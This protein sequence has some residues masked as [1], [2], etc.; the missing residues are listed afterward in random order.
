MTQ[1]TNTK[2]SG[3]EE[4]IENELVNLHGYRA[5]GASAYDKGLCMDTE[6]VLEFVKNTQAENWEKL[7][8][9]YGDEVGQKFLERLDGEIADRG[10]LAVLREG[11]KDRGVKFRL[12]YW[13]PQTGMNPETLTDYEANI[14][15]VT[16]QVK[17]SQQNENSIDMVLFVNGLPIFTVELKNQLTGQTVLHAM[18]QYKSDRDQREKLLSFKR[19]LTHFAVDTEQVYMTTRLS[20]LST[21]FLPFNRGDNNGSGNPVVA[22][23]YKTHYLWE[24]VWGRDSLM[25]LL[26]NFIALQTE[27]KVDKNGR[28]S[29][30]EVLIFPRYHQMQTV[31]RLVADAQARGAGQNYLVQHSAG[32]GKSMTIAW[33]AHRLAELHDASNASVFDGVVVITDRRVL[34]SQLAETIRS[35]EQVDGVVKHV[36][37]SAELRD[38]LEKGTRIISSTLQ[39]FPVIVDA[40]EQTAGKR[41]AVI[42]D[43]AHSSTSGDSMADLRQAL[44]LEDAAEADTKAEQAFKTVEDLLI[45]RM[46]A[47]KVHAPNI[48]FF[49]FTATPKQK[50]L[51][52]FGLEDPLTGKH[53]PF[54]LYSM[55]QAIEEG[56]I[57]DVLKNYTTY[58]TYFA[59]LKKVADDPE[60]DKKKAQRLLVGYVEKHEQ[61]IAKKVKIIVEHFSEKIASEISGQAKAMV[62]TKSRL[63]AVRFKRAFDEYLAEQN[64]PYKSLV[65]FSGTV[66]DGGLEYTEAGMNGVP[67]ANTANE[68]K[69]DDYKFLIVAEKFQTGFDQP[70]LASMYVDKKLSGVSAVQTLSRLN[71]TRYDKEDVFVLDFVNDA[72]DIKKSFQPYYKATLLSEATD[73]NI[74]HDLERDIQGY[75]LFSDLEMRGFVDQYLMGAQPSVLNAALD[76]VVERAV[77]RF[78]EQEMAEFK[79][80]AGDYVRKYAFVSQIV[81]FEDPDLERL[82]L[83]LKFL[84]RKL[85]QG[86]TEL[87]IDVLAAADVDSY[88]IKDKHELQIILD[89]EDSDLEPM[90]AGKNSGGEE[91]DE[92]DPLSKIIKEINER[93]GAEFTNEDKLILNSLSASLLQNEALQGSLAANSPD[94]AKIKFDELFQDRL[95]G[96]LDEHFNLYRKLDENPELKKFVNERIFEFVVR[97]TA[98]SK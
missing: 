52:L 27:E 71:R 33:T 85:P 59:L 50:T 35:F 37:S 78:T 65:A 14:L 2:E 6:L 15:S 1:K 92:K 62:V 45:D 42:I 95:V 4:F 87:P 55:K 56:F 20:G 10:L 86:G 94:A 67:E 22:G 74:L 57:V 8:D 18:R 75:K 19:C 80:R 60:Y 70:L 48:S 53:M 3:F 16:R 49:A 66:V 81:T 77:K 21:Y 83:F 43:E 13:Q 54:S 98:A 69:K 64:H 30:K 72:E 24:E 61:V 32:S 79:S 93:Y 63:H 41:F 89:D 28:K 38:A 51:E 5:R 26:A 12:A 7:S 73:P 46:K 39:K 9:Q 97:K 90:G 11:I 36:E 40:I 58:Q 17:Y 88:A 96:M 68:F 34:D 76:A 44:T 84:R 31:R 29:K 91:G 82:F 25:D 23:K 47:R